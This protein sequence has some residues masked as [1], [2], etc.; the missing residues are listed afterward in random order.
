MIPEIILNIN[1]EW[2]DCETCPIENECEQLTIQYDK[3][4]NKEE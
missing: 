1:C 2:Q 4:N 3:N